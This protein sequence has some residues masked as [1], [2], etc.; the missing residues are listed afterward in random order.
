MIKLRTASWT[1]KFNRTVDRTVDGVGRGKVDMWFVLDDREV[2][3]ETE[4]MVLISVPHGRKDIAEFIARSIMA[5]QRVIQSLPLG[6]PQ[7]QDEQPGFEEELTDGYA[8]AVH[9]G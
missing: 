5:G 1:L 2:D 6:H 4:D 3:P 9:Q 8:S 7:I